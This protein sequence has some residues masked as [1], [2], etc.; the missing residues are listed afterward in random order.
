MMQ[1][2]LRII[3]ENKGFVVI[4][5]VFVI[6]AMSIISSSFSQTTPIPSNQEMPVT[7]PSQVPVESETPTPGESA[8]GEEQD[9][10]QSDQIDQLITDAGADTAMSIVSLGFETDYQITHQDRLA[11]L[12]PIVSDALLGKFSSYYAKE[13]WNQVVVQKTQI[14]PE[15]LD[16]RVSPD[17]SSSYVIFEVEVVYL[18]SDGKPVKSSKPTLFKVKLERTYDFAVWRV[19]YINFN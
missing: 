8:S 17:I 4:L 5:A 2:L 7:A 3:K 11:I 9:I 18:N 12:R 1:I 14:F 19:V 16:V 10:V 15:I 13:D 6:A